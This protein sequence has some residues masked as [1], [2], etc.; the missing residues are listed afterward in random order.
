[1]ADSTKRIILPGEPDVEHQGTKWDKESPKGPPTPETRKI[2]EWF[3]EIYLWLQGLVNDEGV[4]LDLCLERAVAIVEF[5]NRQGMAGIDYFPE[6]GGSM[7]N[8]F[9]YVASA[10]PLAVELYKQVLGSIEKNKDE[11]SVMVANALKKKADAEKYGHE[12]KM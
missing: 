9:A 1:M 2:P 8:R 7:P 5:N 3:K 10:V 12:V 11:F 6:A 4:V